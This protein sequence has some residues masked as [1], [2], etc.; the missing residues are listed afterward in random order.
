MSNT[1]LPII[2]DSEPCSCVDCQ[3]MCRRPCWPI[4]SDVQALMEAGEGNRLM[5]DYWVGGFD[6]DT[7]YDNIYVICPANPG[8]EGANAPEGGFELLFRPLQSSLYSGC[9]FQKDGLCELHERQLKPTEGRAAHHALNQPKLHEEVARY[10]DTEDGR[11]VVAA[12]CERV[13]MNNPYHEED[14]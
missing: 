10:W 12:W 6:D 13:G 2:V 9:V 1:T 5:L 8:H 14:L 11:N 4:P 3:S 7:K